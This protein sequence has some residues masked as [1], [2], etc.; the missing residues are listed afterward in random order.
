MLRRH[1]RGDAP[2]SGTVVGMGGARITVARAVAAFALVVAAIALAAAPAGAFRTPSADELELMAGAAGPP[3]E[4]RCVTGR[5]STVDPRWGALLAKNDLDGCPQAPF[6]WVLRR[7]DPDAPG[8][9]WGELRQDV[10]FGLCSTD[11]PGI[12]DAAG[13]DL[14]VCAPASRQLHVPAAK[15]LAVRPRRL[16]WGAAASVTGIRWSRWGGERAAGRGTFVYADPYGPG[17][18]VAVTVTLTEVDQCGSKRTYL[19][20][21]LKAVDPRLQSRVR[22]YA[23]RWF[24]R[25]P[26]PAGAAAR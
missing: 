9:R 17:W 8:S 6:T 25:C 14:R 15:G 11:L 23:G 19:V 13:V 22:A 1:L 3:V 26:D 10:R 21:Q 12:P 5:I 24:L 4:P 20:K 7:S 18:R 16:P 2:A